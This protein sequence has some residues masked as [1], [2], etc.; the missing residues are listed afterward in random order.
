MHHYISPRNNI[1]T[2]IKTEQ[3]IPQG[4]IYDMD[5]ESYLCMHVTLGDGTYGYL[6]PVGAAYNHQW[7]IGQINVVR[8]NPL[9][10]EIN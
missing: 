8:P 3:F 5:G 1:I 10:F 2:M 4:S 9:A 7:A 6:L